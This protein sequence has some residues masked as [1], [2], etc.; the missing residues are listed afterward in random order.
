MFFIGF[1]HSVENQQ[2]VEYQHRSVEVTMEQMNNFR[3]VN[4]GETYYVR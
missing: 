3:L 4:R 2:I 1:F